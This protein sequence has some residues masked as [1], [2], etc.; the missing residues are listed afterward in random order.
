MKRLEDLPDLPP[1]TP[2]LLAL[3]FL[4]WWLHLRIGIVRRRQATRGA[5]E[6]PVPTWAW[7][8]WL[9]DRTWIGP[10]LAVAAV[11]LIVA[12]AASFLGWEPV[13]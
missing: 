6:G 9:A 1:A 4:V 2:F 3:L 8:R 5:D 10:V 12:V 11:V 7:L 13:P